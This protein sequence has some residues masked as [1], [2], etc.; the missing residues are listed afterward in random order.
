MSIDLSRALDKMRFH[1]E[2]PSA[3][4]KV[5]G[6]NRDA[7]ATP[8]RTGIEAVVSEGLG[9]CSIQNLFRILLRYF[10]FFHKRVD[11]TGIKAVA[12]YSSQ[13]SMR[14]RF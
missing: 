5:K 14:N 13:S 10:L 9:F 12:P 2:G 6:V 11:T 4:R 8:A 7:M 3:V 1:A